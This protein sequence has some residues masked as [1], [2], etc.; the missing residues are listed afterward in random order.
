MDSPRNRWLVTQAN[1]L[2]GLDNDLARGR[3]EC[4]PTIDATRICRTISE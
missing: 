3:Y 1:L 4:Q 2:L